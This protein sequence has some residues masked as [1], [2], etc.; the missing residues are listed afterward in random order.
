[1]KTM[2]ADVDGALQAEII[3]NVGGHFGPKLDNLLILL[4]PDIIIPTGCL[5]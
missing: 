2:L 4:S 3:H 1:M 5:V